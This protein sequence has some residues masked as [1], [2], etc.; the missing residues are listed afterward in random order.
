MK[1]WGILDGQA[2]STG[3]GLHMTFFLAV[4]LY[5]LFSPIFKF[6]FFEGFGWE[7]G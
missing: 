3:R 2:S 1:K 4:S 6:F 7:C 5:L